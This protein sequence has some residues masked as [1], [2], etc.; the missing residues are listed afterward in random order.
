MYTLLSFKN[1][2]GKSDKK[3]P[4][5]KVGQYEYFYRCVF[6]LSVFINHIKLA[7]FFFFFVTLTAPFAV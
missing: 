4:T 1:T 3:F 6:N 7:I 2:L 5:F